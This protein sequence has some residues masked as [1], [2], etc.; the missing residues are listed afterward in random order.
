MAC[1]RISGRQAVYLI[2]ST[3]LPPMLFIPSI[4]YAEAAQASW[5]SVLL[6]TALGL[7][8]GFVISVLGKKF[9]G[10]NMVQYSQIILGKI[11]GSILGLLL[12]FLFIYWAVI[13]TRQ[14]A[15][16]NITM[17]MPETPLV[18]FTAGI[19]ALSVYAARQGLEVLAR[20]CEVV[21]P[22]VILMLLFILAWAAIQITPQ[23]YTP[24]MEPGVLPVV[25]GALTTLYTFTMM[26]FSAMIFAHLNRLSEIGWVI[27][28]ALAVS[29]VLQTI[30]VVFIIGVF[31]PRTDNLMHPTIS[32]ARQVAIANVIERIEFFF[33]LI[34]VLIGFISVG[35]LIYCAVVALAQSLNLQE[36]RPLVLPVGVL[37]TVLSM[38]LW[39]DSI[40]FR[41]IG[42]IILP[43]Y[44]L[45]CQLALPLLL[46]AAAQIRGKGG[47]KE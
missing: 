43:P 12:V 24:V 25:N 45:A 5:L 37:I 18:V 33:L 46:L 22:L 26:I 21:L 47:L 3:L 10:M 8:A 42:F 38:I 15:E 40:S 30:I 27:I 17:F 34:G 28:R 11:P 36:H 23:H 2:L 7:P 6:A 29:G 32:L 31:G 19:V 39:K 35:V 44:L 41:H 13:I 14:F 9:P 1:V 20:T 4:I 16:L